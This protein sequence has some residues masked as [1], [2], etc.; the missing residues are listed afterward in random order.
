MTHATRAATSRRLPR[1]SL[2]GPN[3][4]PLTLRSMLYDISPLVAP[5]FPVFPGDTAFAA[6]W[7]W[8]LA[9]GCPVNVSEVTMSPHTG[10]HADAPLHYDA[11]G[12]SIAE[13]PL[14]TYLGP[15]RVVHAIGVR[16][17]VTAAQLAPHLTGTPPRLL[18]RT[19]A[20]A[21]TAQWD[22]HFAALEPAAVDL[23]H[24]QG[25]R[26]VGI[27]TPS[28]DP[29]QSKTLTAHQRVRAHGMAILE[30]LVLDAVPPGDYELIAL[31]L[32]WQGLDASPVR[33][34]LRPLPL[35]AT[36]S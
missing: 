2:P 30:G 29:E 14:Q 1:C 6:R 18:V 5:G 35:R 23:L 17:L 27:D 22:P 8:E 28:L 9:P 3:P 13:V 26:L 32:R 12:A 10:S 15:C 31:P 21:P 20:Q 19:Y 4:I 36:A 25:V 11:A 7:A 33:A 24:A 16:P 34:V